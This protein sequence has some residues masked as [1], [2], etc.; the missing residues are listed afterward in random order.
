MK[1]FLETGKR[2]TTGNKTVKLKPKLRLLMVLSWLREGCSLKILSRNFWISKAACSKDIR[3]IL[4]RLLA[5]LRT[6]QQK[7]HLPKDWDKH[8]F[9]GV[10]GAIDCTSHFR[11]RVHP[12]QADYYRGD[13]HAH[14]LT[15]QV[16]CSVYGDAIYAVDLGVGRNNDRAMYVLTGVKDVIKKHGA[17]LLADGGYSDKETLVTPVASKGQDW[18]SQQKSLRS[19]VETIIGLVHTWRITTHKFT[20]TPELQ[21][22]VLLCVYELANRHLQKWPLGE[23]TVNK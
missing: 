18:N 9:E 20:S 10:G 23:T 3:Y 5:V 1:E 11:N 13:K 15:A 2:S 19:I 16:L 6:D 7:I 14:F 21:E 12:K 8:L 17:K 22:V 4:P